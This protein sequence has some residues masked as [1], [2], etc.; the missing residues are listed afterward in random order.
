M[1]RWRRPRCI[2][3]SA[4][5]SVN[6]GP[7]PASGVTTGDVLTYQVTSP[8]PASCPAAPRCAS[9]HSGQH[10][11]P[12]RRDGWTVAGSEPDQQCRGRRAGPVTLTFSV[13]VGALPA[14]TRS[15]VSDG[16]PRPGRAPGAR[17][18]SRPPR[19]HRPTSDPDRGQRRPAHPGQTRRAGRRAA[20]PIHH[21]EYRRDGRSRPS[22]PTR[23]GQH[24]L[25]RAG[26]RRLVDRGRQSRPG[27]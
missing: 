26:R 3:P 25:H 22:S 15:I 6:G 5:V 20:V 17:T 13:T 24:E 4:L 10:Q 21:D 8:T 7:V 2:R 23:A 1:P 18:R 11:L 9:R 27:P 14:N 19:C 16:R 12:R